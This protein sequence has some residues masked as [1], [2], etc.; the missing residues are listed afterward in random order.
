MF[1]KSH[2]AIHILYSMSSC[3]FIARKVKS[4]QIFYEPGKNPTKLC[5]VASPGTAMYF[6]EHIDLH[7]LGTVLIDEIMNIFDW[8]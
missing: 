7:K 5:C 1:L 2:S 8:S 3:L 6:Q 4:Y